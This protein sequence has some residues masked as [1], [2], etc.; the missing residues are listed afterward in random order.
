MSSIAFQTFFWKSVP[1][2]FSFTVNDRRFPAEVFPQLP[3]RFD[4]YRV[5]AVLLRRLQPHA[6]ESSFSHQDGR[7]PVVVPNE[8][9]LA[10]GRD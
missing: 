3:L 10:D 6:A 8:F 4:E 2:K 1:T 7:E 5:A 9:E